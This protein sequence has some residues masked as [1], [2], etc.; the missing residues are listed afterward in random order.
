MGDPGNTFSWKLFLNEADAIANSPDN[1]STIFDLD[2]SMGWVQGITSSD[3]NAYI[4][5]YY[6]ETIF[7]NGQTWYLVYAE[8]S[9]DVCVARR[10][11]DLTVTD[12]TFYL[13]LGADF[14][15]CNT[16]HGAVFNWDDIDDNPQPDY[17]DFTVTMHKGLDFSLNSWE[18]TVSANM[19]Q[20]NYSYVSAVALGSSTGGG[21]V[22]VTD[23]GANSI[24]VS[25]SG[26]VNPADQSD[27]ITIRI[28]LTGLVHEDEI[29]ELEITDDTEKARSGTDYEVVTDGNGNG[30]K[31]QQITINPLPATTNIAVVD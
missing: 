13:S 9:A 18:F 23:G 28:N 21:A 4:E 15:T 2:N 12:N 26:P 30:D 25:V 10:R 24:F 1:N 29:I 31:T 3:N 14:A 11:F 7:A 19:S 22:T 6:D 5:I 8:F 17:I 27:E 16:N 20:M